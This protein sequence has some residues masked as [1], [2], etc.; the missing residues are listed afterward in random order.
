MSFDPTARARLGRTRVEVTRL[1]FGSAEIGGLYAP[2]PDDAAIGLVRHAWNAGVRYFDTAPL[3]GYGNAER[4]VGAAL[5]DHPRDSYALSTKVG[6]VLVPIDQ[7]PAGADIDHQAAGGRDDAFYAGTPAV[8]VVFDYSAD[9]VRRSIEASLERLGLERIDIAYIH[10][11][12][13]H[14]EAAIGGAFPGLARLREEGVLGAIGAGMNQSAMLARFAR[15][16]DFDVFMVAGRYTLLDQDAMSELLPLC[17][18]KGIA[19][20]A[21]GL[22]NSGLLADPRPGARFNYMPAPPALVDRAQ[23]IAAVCARH[24][25]PLRAAAIQFPLGHPAVAA[26][27]SGVRRVEHFDEYPAFLRLPI[28]DEMWAELRAQGL[29]APEAP[30]PSAAAPR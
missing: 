2:V 19:V 23:R 24:D 26:I 22:M 4:R 17:E 15:E 9:G 1:G 27:A 28:P 21:V 18:E 12:D 3:Y 5:R 6:R 20:V 29:I 7:V 8:R 11:P 14:W 30:T 13:D 10:D 25:V 16:G